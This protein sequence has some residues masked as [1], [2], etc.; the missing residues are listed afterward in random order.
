[1]VRDR[2]DSGPGRADLRQPDFDVSARIFICLF[3]CYNALIL[4][5]HT[6]KSQA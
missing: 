3:F 2:P 5:A 4:T 1:V 6:E